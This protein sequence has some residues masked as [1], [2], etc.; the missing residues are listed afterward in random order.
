M[1]SS[2]F[3]LAAGPKAIACPQVLKTVVD[4]PLYKDWSI[5]SNDPLHLTEAWVMENSIPPSHLEGMLDPDSAI[6]LNDD[7][8]SVQ[9]TYRLPHA[10]DRQFWLQCQY[11]V[12]AQLTKALPKTIA[13]CVFL[14]HRRIYDW[15]EF[16]AA[17]H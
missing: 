11:G 1:L 2:N 3:A 15:I 6:E 12:H 10:R 4:K 9:S 7:Q 17:C 13:Q 16:E 8:L 14:Q 5:Y